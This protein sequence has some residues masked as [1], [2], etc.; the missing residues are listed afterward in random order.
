MNGF[1]AIAL[2]GR[3]AGLLV[4]GAFLGSLANW[5]IY[6]LAW[7]RRL[8]GPWSPAPRDVPPRR[9]CDRIPIFG[10]LG[11]RREVS[12]HG[13]GYWIRP[14]LI[15]LACGFGV[16]WLYWWQIDRLALVPG[17]VPRP[18][19]VEYGA[20]FHLQF[21]VFIVFF[22]LMLVAS[23]IDIDE[24][25]IPDAITVP[26]TLLALVVAGLFSKTGLS[27]LTVCPD[28]LPVD[29]FWPLVTPKIWPTMTLTSPATPPEWLLGPIGLGIGLMCFWGWCFAMSDR[30]WYGR[31]GVARAWRVFWAHLRRASNTPYVIGLAVVGPIGI[32][33]VWRFAG[34]AGWIGLLSAL[35]G[36]ATAGGLVWAVRLIGGSVLG[37]EAMGFGDVTLMAMIG[38]VLGWQASV[39]L[40]FI[41][42]LLALLIGL[43]SLVLH[44]ESEIP[45]GPFLCLAATVILLRWPA[46]WTAAAPRFELGLV[47]PTI[48]G[49]GLVLLALLLWLV[50]LFKRWLGID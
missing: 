27:A 49:I 6:R 16:A 29:G 21:V 2:E 32:G 13:T 18:A 33:L 5:A 26:G 45:Y 1:D 11:L 22:W 50:Q 48:L 25:L 20:I 47:V 14:M 44:R 43:G 38:A 36:M 12:V 10:W 46:I 9:A 8:I 41:A 37:R 39:L 23:L 3:L 7:N 15:E 4:L 42:P 17:W 30:V 31:H 19:P 35:V 28:W 24:K 34:A 40:F